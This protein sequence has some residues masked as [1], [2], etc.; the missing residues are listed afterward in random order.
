MKLIALVSCSCVPN[1]TKQ[2]FGV[3]VDNLQEL[4]KEFDDDGDGLFNR[5]EFSKLCQQLEERK[6]A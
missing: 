4:V 2:R 1:K 3:G 6:K 5:R